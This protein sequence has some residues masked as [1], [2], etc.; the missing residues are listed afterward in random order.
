MN[1]IFTK[2][3][4]LFSGEN[5]IVSQLTKSV[6]TFVTTSGEKE[7]LKQDM[8]RILKSHEENL[9]SEL[10]ERL[11]IDMNSDSWLSKNIRPMVLIFILTVY[12]FFSI[13][14]TEAVGLD[15]NE[16]YI[17]LLGNWGMMIMSFY[18]GSRGVEKIMETMGKY[19]IGRK[20]R[21]ERD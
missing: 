12:S 6:D 9:Q 16:A 3:A 8:L 1:P 19:N 13:V 18:F 17:E 14:D 4:S 10:T 11:R 15:I 7:Q 20:R 5:G 2:I 21:N